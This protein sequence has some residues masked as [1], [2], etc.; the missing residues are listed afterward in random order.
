MKT[1]HKAM[2]PLCTY[3]TNMEI[4]KP[5]HVMSTAENTD[6]KTKASTANGDVQAASM[7]E[8]ALEAVTQALMK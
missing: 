3:C 8:F 4:Q 7:V 1:G 6:R 2:A 5:Y